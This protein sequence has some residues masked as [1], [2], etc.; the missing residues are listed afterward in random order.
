MGPELMERM[1]AQCARFGT[2]FK[3]G[4]ETADLSKRP[5][6]LT[7]SNGETVVADAL[8]IATGA[9]ARYLGLEN[10]SRL[11]GRQSLHARP[12]MAFSFG[13]FARRGCRWW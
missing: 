3:Y 2:E 7:T 11:L 9:T 10:E 4:I 6:T 5:F 12:A 13:T 1:K 8:V